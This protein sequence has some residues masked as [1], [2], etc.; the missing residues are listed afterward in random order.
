MLEMTKLAHPI[1][2]S[3]EELDLVAA[4]TG[5]CGCQDG[6]SLIRT[7]AT[8]MCSAETKFRLA[9]CPSSPKSLLG[10][11]GMH[12]RTASPAGEAVLR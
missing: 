8:S 10:K 9:C 3:D 1:E 5:G 11:G 4:G 7:G 2:L 6:G 12:R